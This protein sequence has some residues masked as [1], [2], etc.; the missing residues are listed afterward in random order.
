[1]LNKYI[2][3]AKEFQVHVLPPNINKSKMNFTI[4]K[5]HSC[6]FK[7]NKFFVSL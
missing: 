7:Q 1:M 3:D 6:I 4:Y 2:L 5:G